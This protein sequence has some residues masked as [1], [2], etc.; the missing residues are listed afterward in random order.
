MGR[1]PPI[2]RRPFT[3]PNAGR[4][5][6][7]SSESCEEVAGGGPIARARWLRKN[8][9]EAERR[10]WHALRLLK[11]LGLHFRRQ[12][13]IGP[14]FADFACHRSRLVVEL[15]GSQHTE[16]AAIEYDARRTAYLNR[17]GYRVL[18]FWNSE[19]LSGGDRIVEIIIAAAR[20]PPTRPAAPGDLPA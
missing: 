18:R 1:L 19:I 15:D 11:P 13:P 7:L 9:T 12:P 8:P 3:S 17:R 20:K 14:Y 16:S 6:P 10:L 4:S 5:P 2:N